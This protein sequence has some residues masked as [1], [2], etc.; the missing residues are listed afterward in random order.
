MLGLG[1]LNKDERKIDFIRNGMETIEK[2][3]IR[4]EIIGA[5]LCNNSN[6]F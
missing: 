6:C 1:L 5:G 2:E 3:P 4:S